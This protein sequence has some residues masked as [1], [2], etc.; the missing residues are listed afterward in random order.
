MWGYGRGEGW[1]LRQP[2]SGQVDILVVTSPLYIGSGV[3][4]CSCQFSSGSSK[5]GSIAPI[6]INIGPP[7]VTSAQHWSD[8][9]DCVTVVGRSAIFM[10]TNEFSLLDT[11]AQQINSLTYNLGN[12]TPSHLWYFTLYYHHCRGHLYHL[13]LVYLYISCTWCFS[14]LP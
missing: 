3:D 12:S 1:T 4:A 6:W 11:S 2:Q 5:Q 10:H 14:T 8:S 13:N 9:G 7:S